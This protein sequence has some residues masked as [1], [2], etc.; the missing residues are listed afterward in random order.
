MRD[1]LPVLSFSKRDDLR[2]WL[3]TGHSTSQGIWVRLFKRN[4]GVTSISFEDLL[5]EGLCFGWSESLRH[6]YDDHSYLQKFTP[7]KSKGTTSAR[8]KAHIK[9]LIAAGLMTPAGLAVL[10]AKDLE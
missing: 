7:R 2:A 1:G 6:G 10:N 9:R 5:D 3:E 4:S 8:N